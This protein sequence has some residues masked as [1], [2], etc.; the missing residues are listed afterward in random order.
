MLLFIRMENVNFIITMAG[1][2]RR[3]SGAGFRTP[4][5]MLEAA[6]R[7]LFE[8]A[9]GSL[10]LGLPGKVVLVALA[11]HDEEF[12]ARRFIE[13]RMK[14]LAPGKSWDLVLLEAPTRGQAETALAAE[15]A[16]GP[17]EGLAIYNIDTAFTS[18]TLE[19]RL[20]D[21]ALRRDGVIGCFRLEGADDK[22]SFAETGPGG[23]V[24]RTAEKEQISSNALTGFY[25]FSRASDFFGAARRQIGS[26]AAVRGEFYVAPM[27][28]ELIAAGGKFVLDT[29]SELVP[30]GTPADL[31]RLKGGA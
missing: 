31:E 6:G 19:G 29:A 27:Y 8:H 14:E 11:A 26:G 12:G 22:W 15:P 9:L 1:L 23:L 17:G 4:K 5:Y 3:F 28:N 10:P 18:P 7:T 13:G 30:L 24:T 16:V 2:S 25:H 20:G 21:P